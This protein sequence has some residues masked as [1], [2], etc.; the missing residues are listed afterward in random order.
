MPRKLTDAEAKQFRRLL[1]KVGDDYLLP[2]LWPDYLPRKRGRRECA[3]DTPA[4]LAQHELFLR[5]AMRERGMSR[6]AALHWAFDSTYKKLEKLGADSAL[7]AH[8]GPNANALV[9]RLS[10]KLREGGYHKRGIKTLMP[11]EWL[12]AGID[13][14]KF[15]AFP[16]AK[17]K[18]SI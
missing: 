14:A 6:N 12:E 4:A 3:A 1:K 18:D 11:Q 17:T 15:T 5:T 13:P 16:P 10:R 7:I 8:F 2:L 9:A